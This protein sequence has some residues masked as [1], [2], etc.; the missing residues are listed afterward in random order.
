MR[1]L[2]KPL[3]HSFLVLGSVIALSNCGNSKNEDDSQI[4]TTV[5]RQKNA[6]LSTTTVMGA[7][8]VVTP[9]NVHPRLATTTT[10]STGTTQPPVLAT[11]TTASTGTTQPPV[12][13]TTT[14][15]YRTYTTP[16]QKTYG[17]VRPVPTTVKKP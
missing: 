5:P 16:P 13:A 8:K 6:A 1:T 15:V 17:P 9:K 3:F 4:G 10:A 11:T 7:P 12:L 14:T 2:L